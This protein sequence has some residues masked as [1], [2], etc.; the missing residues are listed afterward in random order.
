MC[1]SQLLRQ[2]FERAN[3]NISC[4]AYFAYAMAFGGLINRATFSI[5]QVIYSSKTSHFPQKIV[6][7]L[8]LLELKAS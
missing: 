4:K 7:T 1:S 2:L 6:T 5:I 8:K 3:S